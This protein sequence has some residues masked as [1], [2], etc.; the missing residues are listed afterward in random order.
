MTDTA[1]SPLR[2]R[3]IEDMAIRQ[4]KASTQHTYVRFVKDFSMFFGR[5]PNKA[6][7]EDVRRY[8][9]HLISRGVSPFTI[10]ATMTALRFFFRITVRR[11]DIANHI[12]LVPQPRKLPVILSPEEVARLLE[13]ARNPKYKAALAVAYGAGLRISEIVSLKVSDIDSERMLIRVEQG[14]GRADR[15]A[16]LSLHL[17]ELLR[18]W[19]LV[20]RPKGYLFPGQDCIN[21]LTTRHLH[22][23]CVEAARAAGITKRVSPHTLRHY[24]PYR[25]ISGSFKDPAEFIGNIGST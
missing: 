20:L 3:M 12:P 2:R 21:P 25:I 9:L 17:L 18:N 10:N 15:Y 5:S 13:A 19:W 8:Q 24:L 1:I 6:A 7:F 14:K 16:M 22:R 23:I 11:F 4:F